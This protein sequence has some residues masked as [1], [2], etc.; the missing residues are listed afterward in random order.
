LADRSTFIAKTNKHSLHALSQTQLAAFR[1]P[2]SFTLGFSLAVFRRKM[3]GLHAKMDGLHGKMETLHARM[4]GLHG[5]MDGLH[6]RIEGFASRIDG[7]RV[8]IDVLTGG[9][10]VCASRYL[11]II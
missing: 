10:R 5:K 7:L 11:A 9:M 2:V 3:E 1:A 4:D 8:R 6:A